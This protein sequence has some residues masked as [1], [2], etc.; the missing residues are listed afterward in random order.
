MN[1]KYVAFLRGI[2]VG[3]HKIIKMEDLRG[4]LESFGY[5]N[6]GTFIQSG[7]AIF[8]T[9]NANTDRLEKEVQSKLAKSLGYE[10]EIFL[11]TIG[12]VG[13][14]AANSPFQDDKNSTVYVAF[15]RREPGSKARDR[16]LALQNKVDEF[17]VPG[18]EVYWFRHRDKGES[19]FTN[20]MLEKILDMPSTMRNMTSIR[21]IVDKYS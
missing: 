7:N 2:N 15:L 9:P 3:G 1:T 14:I 21:K 20:N 17:A 16:L 13:E 11:R 12:E 18:R 8:E 19:K 5:V 10:V 6:V 4:M